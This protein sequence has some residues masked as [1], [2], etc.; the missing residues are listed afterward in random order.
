MRWQ[1]RTARGR[2]GHAI[3]VAQIPRPPLLKHWCHRCYE[4]ELLRAELQK[5]PEIFTFLPNGKIGLTSWYQRCSSSPTSLPSP[6]VA[7]S[8]P[9]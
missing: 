9:P 3:L 5:H 2:F 1:P 7:G 6:S 4:I 8:P